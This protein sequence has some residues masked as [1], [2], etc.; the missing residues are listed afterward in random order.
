[1]SALIFVTLFSVRIIISILLV[2]GEVQELDLGPIASTWQSQKSD[3]V[4]FPHFTV[5]V[6]ALYQIRVAGAKLRV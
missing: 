1:M 2:L 6:T 3:P 5:S 4:L